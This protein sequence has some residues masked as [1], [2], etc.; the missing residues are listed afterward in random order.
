HAEEWCGAPMA[1]SS[2]SPETYREIFAETGFTIV[3]EAIEGA[4][5]DEE[6]HWWVLVERTSTGSGE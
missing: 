1:W 6:R 4:P 5:G 2:L 3:E